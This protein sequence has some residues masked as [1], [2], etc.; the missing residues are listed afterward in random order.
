MFFNLIPLLTALIAAWLLSESLAPY[1]ALGGA[2]TVAG[3]LLAEWWKAPPAHL[4][5]AEGSA[6]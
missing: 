2:L 5:A 4:E 6:S 3:V 1:H